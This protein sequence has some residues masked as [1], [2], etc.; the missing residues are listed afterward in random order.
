MIYVVYYNHWDTMENLY[1]GTSYDTA[2]KVLEAKA[3]RHG[4]AVVYLQTW[5]DGI[6]MSDKSSKEVLPNELG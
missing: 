1:V 3:G 4:K 6:M 2:Y 5:E